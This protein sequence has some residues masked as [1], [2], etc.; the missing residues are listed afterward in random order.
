MGEWQHV[1]WV[2]GPYM[3]LLGTILCMIDGAWSEAPQSYT[4]YY[5]HCDH[6]F[7]PH[8][9]PMHHHS[10]NNHSKYLQNKFVCYPNY[11]KLQCD[12][13]WLGIYDFFL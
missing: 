4:R 7:D 1:Y 13:E 11:K 2:C 6:N 9:Q 12:Y 10:Y 8:L 3:G 5:M